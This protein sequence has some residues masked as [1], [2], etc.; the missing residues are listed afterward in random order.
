MALCATLF[1][2]LPSAQAEVLGGLSFPAVGPY[3][4]FLNQINVLECVNFSETNV[5]IKLDIYRDSGERFADR[6]FTIKRDGTEHITLNEFQ[7]QSGI[8]I[9][10]SYGTFKL[11]LLTEGQLSIACMVVV[12]RT[13][14]TGVEYAFAL[15]M[16]APHSGKTRGLYNSIDPSL[17]AVPTVNYL[18]VYNPS[19]K[20]ISGNLR[21]YQ[22]S[23]ALLFEREITLE[24]AA[25]TDIALGHE[26]GQITG[27]YELVFPS[28]QEYGAHLVRSHRMDT[29]VPYDFAFSLEQ[30]KNSCGTTLSGS[31]MASAVNWLEMGNPNPD[32]L[33]VRVTVRDRFGQVNHTE[34]PT[35]APFSQFNVYLNPHISPDG[36]P[37]VGSVT[38]ECL[39]PDAPLIAQ[40]AF[41]GLP[42]STVRWAYVDQASGLADNIE[43]N[44]VVAAFN[45]GFNAANWLKLFN[46][47][48]ATYDLNYETIAANGS[49]IAQLSST[50]SGNGSLD[51][52]LHVYS[53][54]NVFGSARMFHPAPLGLIE[55]NL[56]RVFYGQDGIEE[57]LPIPII[58]LEQEVD[59]N[60]PTSCVPSVWSTSVTA[61]EG[62]ANSIPLPMSDSCGTA[63]DYE[64]LDYPNHGTLNKDEQNAIYTP[65]HELLFDSFR[66]K[67]NNGV[68]E[69]DEAVV[70]I[71]VVSGPAS[72]AGNA[73]SLA[74]YRDRLSRDEAA[75]VLRRMAFG[76][77]HE[78][79]DIAINQ[80]VDAL[81]DAF[82][83]EQDSSEAISQI[84]DKT[85]QHPLNC[86][87]DCLVIGHTRNIRKLALAHARF[88]ASFREFMAMVVFHNHFAINFETFRTRYTAW[89]A[90]QYLQMLEDYSLENFGTLAYSMLHHGAYQEWLD[91]FHNWWQNPVENLGRELLELVTFGFNDPITLEPTH[92]ELDM[93]GA[94]RATAGFTKP[95]WEFWEE[96]PNKIRAPCPAP[97]N[98]SRECVVDLQH[99]F[100]LY[101][102]PTLDPSQFSLRH[103]AANSTDDCD[104]EEG[105]DYNNTCVMRNGSKMC[106]HAYDSYCNVSGFNWK[107]T[108]WMRFPNDPEQITL[109][110]GKPY[111]ITLPNEDD[112]QGLT[113]QL[114]FQLLLYGSDKTAR[115]VSAKIFRHLAHAE[116]TADMVDE[117]TQSF[118]NSGLAMKPLLRKILKSSAL[119]SPESASNCIISPFEYLI[120]CLRSAEIPTNDLF[121]NNGQDN[122]ND[123]WG[124]LLDTFEL[125]G[126]NPMMLP[127]VFGVKAC[128]VSQDR[129]VE[130]GE[131]W[132]GDGRL[133][134]L[135]KSIDRL[136]DQAE[137]IED[138]DWAEVLGTHSSSRSLV[139]AT[140]S[141]LRLSANSTEKALYR[142]YVETNAETGERKAWNPTAHPWQKL[143]YRGLIKLMLSTSRAHMK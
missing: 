143:K 20:V 138:T 47:T 4:G 11:S 139:N 89:Y 108:R 46:T 10:D 9:A 15:P 32:P 66:F 23:G 44:S 124:T 31:T 69:T 25:R 39:T 131:V 50:F 111:E 85:F 70:T 100:V 74:P 49:I 55:G 101:R 72:F 56:V 75:F 18:A 107:D 6:E 96:D 3:N 103:C 126:F 17:S 118:L 122:F 29:V 102:G 119:Y 105:F 42:T 112:S 133:I 132:L 86:W 129:V 60:H 116:P 35:I 97:Y 93:E 8:G 99:N 5:T 115:N 43:G 81:I 59:S 36:E 140:L 67:A 68:L 98:P 37:T 21:V 127:S 57:I 14:A 90:P 53:G 63:L 136:M 26:H 73:N 58:I 79:I 95:G 40:S 22:Q 84:S 117:L 94:T 128:G 78:Y 82:F 61:V 38:V 80:G 91:N 134:T 106:T 110:E 109:F 135:D 114:L 34:E 16:R 88:G 52:P 41:Y 137:S 12:Y 141:V 30:F 87:G 64:I 113:P 120:G 51:E 13:T 76:G 24:P 19:D 65:G 83:A 142:E 27:L 54:G 123:M 121:R 125:T 48:S 77:K 2:L 92:N 33:D 1:F 130:R 71:E 7:D 62:I 104:C 28:N 45:N